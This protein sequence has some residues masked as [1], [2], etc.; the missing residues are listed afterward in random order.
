MPF[1]KLFNISREIEL[2]I[3]VVTGKGFIKLV[4]YLELEY[5]HKLVSLNK[6]K[7][8][9]EKKLKLKLAR[10]LTTNSTCH[11][12]SACWEMHFSVL[13]MQSLT[14]KLTNVVNTWSLSDCVFS[15]VHNN[16]K[17]RVVVISPE[18]ALGLQLTIK[19]GFNISSPM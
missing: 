9:D 19:D 5:H 2:Q 15:C 14:E 4:G 13:L 18:H 12:I 10:A 16:T 6:E 17:N 11:F 7:H 8:Y 3:S 1:N